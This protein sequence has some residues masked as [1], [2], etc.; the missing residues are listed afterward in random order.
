MTSRPNGRRPTSPKSTCRGSVGAVLLLLAFAEPSRADLLGWLAGDTTNAAIEKINEA[1]AQ[2]ISQL[3][4]GFD[5]T[6]HSLLDQGAHQGNLLLVQGGNEMQLVVASARAQFGSEMDKQV[7]Q[8]SAQ[9]KPFLVE[10]ERFQLSVSELQKNAVDMEDLVALDLQDL[11][12]SQSYF[13]VRRVLG[14]VLVQ[15]T[16]DNYRIVL[17]GPHFGIASADEKI[18]FDAR[19]NGTSLGS[20]ELGTAPDDAVF[21][22]PAAALKDSFQTHSLVTLPLSV[23][24]TR[25]TPKVFWLF[26]G[27]HDVINHSFEISLM[28]DYAGEMQV[29]TH[30]PIFA[31]MPSLEPEQQ[32]KIVTS[33][34][35]F[36]FTVANPAVLSEPSAGQQ[37]ISDTIVSVCHADMR[38]A[39]VFPNGTVRFSSDPIFTGGWDTPKYI[40]SHATDWDEATNEVLTTWGI[41]WSTWSNNAC[42]PLN[43]GRHCHVPPQVLLSNSSPTTKDATGCHD[44][45]LAPPQWRN[46]HTS[47]TVDVI[48]GTAAL[49][50]PWSLTFQPLSFVQRGY[51]NDTVVMVPVFASKP[52]LIEINNPQGTTSDV[53]FVPT[54]GKP[55]PGDLGRDITA[56]L[57]VR[58]QGDVGD[59]RRYLYSFAYPETLR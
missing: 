53:N 41:S 42:G 59:V 4:E 48:G 28:P 37:K 7:S 23:S 33:P 27:S 18:S 5:Q 38:P 22:V 14:S 34:T 44:T 12:L 58:S 31:W 40:G 10:L 17:R 24:I 20:P 56:S 55:K 47:V 45:S 51:Q 29:V 35:T 43:S 26:G 54:V 46:N 1:A 52:T 3:L 16:A 19:L 50:A 57:R 21:S 39:R 9:L 30:R 11:P 25:D 13:G 8:A 49:P 6:S 2:R 32:D 15:N 36:S